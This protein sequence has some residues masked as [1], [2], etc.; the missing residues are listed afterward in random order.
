MLS[1]NEA[2][3]KVLGCRISIKTA[4]VSILNSL[5]LVLA[6]DVI[7]NDDIPVYNNSAMD[8]YAVR[9]E[10]IKGA[11]K[12]H[13]ARLML[14]D[15]DLPAG[16]L[17]S[18]KISPGYCMSIMTGAPVP[19]GC[20]AVIMKE[21]T[22]KDGKNILIFKECPKGENI[23]YRGEDIKKGDIV[24][25]KGVRIFPAD[26]GVMASLGKN[27]VLV[28]KPPLVGIISTG[29]ELLKIEEEL[30]EGRVRDSNSYSLSAQLAEIGIKYIRYGI[31]RDKKEVLK[32]KISGAL[33]ECDIL[34]ISGGVSV[35]DYDFVKEML[36]EIGAKLV[37][38]K[39]NQKPGKPL[40][41]LTYGD[42]F[43]FGLPG[44]PVSVMVCF[45][46]YVRPLIMRVMGNKDLLRPVIRAR[47]SHDFKKN[48]GRTDFA[49]VILTRKGSNYFFKST[50]K[51]GSGILTS[52]VKADGIAVFSEDAGDIKK[53]SEVKV[54]YLKDKQLN[55]KV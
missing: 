4:Y 8:G 12:D 23:R 44:N 11:D 38:W 2:Q 49:R 37:F 27:K 54:F 10:D 36:V 41:F 7:S 51:Q 22:R 9:A 1:V 45:E 16:R 39:V 20:N 55:I 50:G 31:I 47:A 48:R 14:L 3:D 42:K 19:A 17:P 25:K 21:D 53:D 46:M 32:K 29:D 15:E 18:I 28:N 13:P 6:E 5:G 30:E 52:M 35:G 24:L 33:S 34:L 40:V 26:I 43:I